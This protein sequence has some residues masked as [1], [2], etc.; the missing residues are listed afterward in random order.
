MRVSMKIN[1]NMKV[2]DYQHYSENA[3]DFPDHLCLAPALHLT[4][5]ITCIQDLPLA[6]VFYK[7]YMSSTKASAHEALENLESDIALITEAADLINRKQDIKAFA[8]LERM[9]EKSY[10]ID[11]KSVV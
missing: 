10:A 3:K 1:T 9:E 8:V 2:A 6:L 4:R 5:G 7:R 11:W